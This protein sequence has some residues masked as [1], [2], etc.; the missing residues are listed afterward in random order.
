MLALA[1]HQ[2][3]MR[4]LDR[5][6]FLLLDAIP[7]QRVILDPEAIALHRDL[8]SELAARAA[9]GW[10]RERVALGSTPLD[11]ATYN[12]LEEA[13][14]GVHEMAAALERG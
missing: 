11:E 6:R 4:S 3:I 10:R 14:T 8:V 2:A 5:G 12:R 13:A 1:R 9:R 7:D